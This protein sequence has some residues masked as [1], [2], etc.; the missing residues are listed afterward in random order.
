MNEEESLKMSQAPN[1]IF[2]DQ[3]STYDRLMRQSKKLGGVATTTLHDVKEVLNREITFPTSSRSHHPH[4]PFRDKLSLSRRVKSRHQAELERAAQLR[5]TVQ[6]AHE[7]LASVDTVFPVTLF[8]DTIV[9]DRSKISIKKRSF[10]LTSNVISFRIEDVLNVSCGVGP[11]FGSL[12][13]ASRVMS[14]IDHFQID[15]LW[16]KDAVFLK[17]LIQG[18]IIATNSKLETDQLSVEEMIETLYE[19]GIDSDS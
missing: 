12:T 11:I 13:I 10:F 16:R 9:I 18:H 6:K 2:P 3:P 1:D 7:V 19:L 17:N 14:S 8:P 4:T 5:Q 15:H